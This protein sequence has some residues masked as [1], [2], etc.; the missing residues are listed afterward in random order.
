MLNFNLRGTKRKSKQ[1]T[2]PYCKKSQQALTFS[3][4]TCNFCRRSFYYGDRDWM[5]VKPKGEVDGNSQ[6]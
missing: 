5:V 1:V 2:C 3:N 4:V 6:V